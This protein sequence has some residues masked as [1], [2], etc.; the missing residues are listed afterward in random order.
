MVFSEG[1]IEKMFC[2]KCGA[3]IADNVKFC[4]KCGEKLVQ[5]ETSDSVKKETVE[6][7]NVHK[8]KDKKKTSLILCGIGGVFV[9]LLVGIIGIFAMNNSSYKSL[10]PLYENVEIPEI[11]IY[12]KNIEAGEK[13]AGI[14]WDSTLFYWLEDIKQDSDEDGYLANCYIRK[15][16]MKNSENGN[17]IQYEIYCDPTTNEIYKIV[18]IEPTETGLEL[19]DYYYQD[20][21]PNF[22]FKR[23][24][25]VYT[26][27]YATP[28]KTGERYYFANDVMARW[29]MIEEP[30]VIEEYVLTNSDSA[31]YVQMN[32]FEQTADVQQRYGEKELEVL[33]V[34]Y[35]TYQAVNTQSAVGIVSGS[36]K[37]TTEEPIKDLV[38]DIFR[39]SDNELLYRTKTDENGIFETN[40]Y[41]DKEECYLLV[42]GDKTYQ[43]SIVY[44]VNLNDSAVNMTYANIVMNKESGDEYPVELAMYEATKVHTDENS[45]VVQ[46]I[47]N[48][49]TAIIRKGTDVYEGESVAEVEANTDGKVLVNLPSGTYTA[50]VK[51]EGYISTFVE[52]VV[53]EEKASISGYLLPQIADGTT[54]IV[55]TWDDP[56]VDLDL[57]LFTP[58]QAEGGDMAYIGGKVLNDEHGNALVADNTAGCEVMYVNTVLQ[59]SYKLYVNDYNNSVNGNYTANTLAGVDVT[60]YVYD[61][62]G[63]VNKYYYPVGQNG[64]VWE[65]VELNG[66]Q[67]TPSH[68]VYTQLEDKKWWTENKTI[69]IEQ[70][71]EEAMAAYERFLNNEEVVYWNGGTY[72]LSE[73]KGEMQKLERIESVEYAY[74]DCG[75]DGMREFFVRFV[76]EPWEGEMRASGIDMLITYKNEKLECINK[77]NYL[78]WENW[79]SYSGIRVDIDY[80]GNVYNVGELY[81]IDEQGE[82]HELAWWNR[83]SAQTISAIAYGYED[84]LLGNTSEY[85]D[86]EKMAYLYLQTGGEDYSGSYW[87]IGSDMYMQDQVSGEFKQ[88]LLQNGTKCYTENEIKE[89]IILYVIQV[90]GDE[91]KAKEILSYNGGVELK[92]LSTEKK[93]TVGEEEFTDEV[94]TFVKNKELY[95]E[96]LLAALKEQQTINDLS[97]L[98]YQYYFKD[99]NNDA[100]DE[101][102]LYKSE[103]ISINT[104]YIY[105]Y[106][107]GKAKKI[108]ERMDDMPYEFVE[109]LTK[110]GFCISGTT[111]NGCEKRK[112][113]YKV[114]KNNVEIVAE[115]YSSEY[116]NNDE[117]G[118]FIYDMYVDGIGFLTEKEDYEK[119][120]KDYIDKN[121]DVEMTE[122][123]WIMLSDNL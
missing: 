61:S 35:N 105:S 34:S 6:K 43:D 97:E 93:N 46:E 29:R 68:R 42:H 91:A 104:I 56:T 122:E 11:D 111:T 41:L 24:D 106:L 101:L 77:W 57:T 121:V 39:T 49:T 8:E 20:G 80:N 107:D 44:G 63:L 62:N 51:A 115:F 82:A 17:V 64:V 118:T 36:V 81:L 84:Y 79:I 13:Q 83:S 19:T 99:F 86:L 38:V 100:C 112:T 120:L 74:I 12:A 18:S 58:F 26:P 114:E 45:E 15:M 54:G 27:T 3:Q 113:F 78:G 66:T 88:Y 75:L 96:I 89:S 71:N 72:Y 103:N 65:V 4:D 53:G 5:K 1:E 2:R 60:I 95:K 48:G 25:S 117:T 10:K 119:Q 33:N 85:Y 23:T 31:S 32:Y 21:V 9:L 87:R 37:N 94:I 59:G 16:L 76:A 14:K 22:C 110:D 90:V 7:E 40:V 55:M 67:L 50:E 30:N 73:L 28:N 92:V 70:L 109:S 102:V 47:V 69:T 116:W 98:Q 108:F 52:V 123:K